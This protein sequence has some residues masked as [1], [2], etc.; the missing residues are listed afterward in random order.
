MIDFEFTGLIGMLGLMMV[1]LILRRRGRSLEYLFFFAVF[2]IYLLFG[3]KETLL[4]IDIS[5][6][7]L[8]V[9]RRE[10]SFTDR[11]NL[12]PL[13]YGPYATFESIFPAVSQNILLT[14]P[15]GFG[16]CFLTRLKPQIFLWLGFAVGLGIEAAQLAI[17]IPLGFPYRVTDINDVLANAAGVMLGYAGFRLFAWAYLG[18][19]NRTGRQP[20][21]LAGFIYE[22]AAE[23]TEQYP[24]GSRD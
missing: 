17:S 5:A 12:I 20:T 13:F 8:E 23:S 21:G 3:I 18:L 7:Y 15:F 16:I 24:R 9:M 2:W 1:L 6:D 22:T 11:L 14:L 10:V 4:P 19:V